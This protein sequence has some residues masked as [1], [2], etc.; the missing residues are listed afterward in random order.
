MRT[1]RHSTRRSPGKPAPAV[2]AELRPVL[3]AIITRTDEVC[4]KY[5]N[6][7]YAVL[8]RR[9]A[10]LLCSISPSPVES[11]RPQSWACA[12]LYALGK[13]NFL[14]DKTEK[15]HLQA[16]ELCALCGVS[17]GNASPKANTILDLLQIIPLDPEWSLPSRLA[18]NPL[19]WIL[20]VNGVLLDIRD[21][22]RE[23]QEVALAQGLIPFIPGDPSG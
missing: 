17:P 7:E 10:T 23:V 19:V 13:V 9:M 8:A 1:T 4:R 3:D 11:A 22:P 2:G 14:F 21:A 15:P 20:S 5:L 18:D 12:I 16:D 6:E